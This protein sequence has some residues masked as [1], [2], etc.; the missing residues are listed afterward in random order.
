MTLG[1]FRASPCA[2]LPTGSPPMF[3]ILTA[4]ALMSSACRDD[5]PAPKEPPAKEVLSAITE[6]GRSLAGYDDA[7]WH[8][9]DA[10]VAKKPKAGSV[11]RYIARKTDKGW[12]VAFG[13]L[14]AERD[15][16]LVAY[17]ATQG[18]D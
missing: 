7:C 3:V 15:R 11:A 16:F 13:K 6:R 2:Q 10:L 8:A 9:S 12:T 1:R 18:K 14:G 4:L 17:E 5:P